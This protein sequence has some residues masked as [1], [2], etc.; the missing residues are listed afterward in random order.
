MM[1]NYS[2]RLI[3]G[4][5]N[6]SANKTKKKA[7][8]MLNYAEKLGFRFF[9][10]APLYSRGYSE[11]LI[12]E[13]FN[14]KKDI[15]VM[16]KVGNYPIP[17]I[18]IPASIALPLNSLKNNL[19]LWSYKKSKKVSLISENNLIVKDN[20]INQVK[21]SRKNLNYLIIEGILFHEINPFKLNNNQVEELNIYLNN[22]NIK[23]LGYAGKFHKELTEF[24]LPNWMKIL[25][26]EIP[27][28]LNETNEFEILKLIDKNKDIE[29]RF[30]NIFREVNLIDRRMKAAKKILNDFPNTKI[31]FQTKSL[32]RLK[33]NFLFF[34]S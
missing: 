4:C 22:L 25:Q 27:F 14:F 17:K 3:F 28:E 2:E 8:A 20:F 26:L 33:N 10:T 11:L 23:K 30:F 9:D 32:K 21:N 34:T 5:C 19:K 24:N 6:L 12:G 31:I 18:Y 29:F 15:K 7:L 13:A 1:N 16:T